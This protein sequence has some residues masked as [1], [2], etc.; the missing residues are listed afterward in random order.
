MLNPRF[1]GTADEPF[2][3]LSL[4]EQES[5]GWHDAATFLGRTILGRL[6]AGQPSLLQKPARSKGIAF[7]DT[8]LGRN[9]TPSETPPNLGRGSPT[10]SGTLFFAFLSELCVRF[11]FFS[12]KDAKK[13]LGR[14]TDAH[15]QT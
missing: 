8:T 2:D 15:K 14:V 10:N 7:A 5:F 13:S 9:L 6:F 4:L 1:R 12:R 3:Y 11:R